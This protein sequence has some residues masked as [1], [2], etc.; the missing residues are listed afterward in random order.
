MEAL[1]HR[2]TKGSLG[3]SE[4][5]D[6]EVLQQVLTQHLLMQ[7][8]PVVVQCDALDDLPSAEAVRQIVASD[9]PKIPADE[10]E[11]GLLGA[12][13]S[14]VTAM[15][16][17]RL[18]EREIQLKFNVPAETVQILQMRLNSGAKTE[19]TIREDILNDVMSLLEAPWLKIEQK[20][21]RLDN[22][23]LT[24]TS[25]GKRNQLSQGNA[26]TVL[27]VFTLAL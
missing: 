9:L 24:L 27:V 20:G 11:Q 7:R 15:L 13:R 18:T 8:S 25:N 14:A 4:H 26:W 21:Y 2:L 19:G 6:T 12:V 23:T 16:Q 22:R 17:G 3:A 5:I 1:Q 10:I